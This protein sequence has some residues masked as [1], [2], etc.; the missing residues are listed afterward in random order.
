MGYRLIGMRMGKRGLN[1]LGKNFYDM[2]WKHNGM[3]TG[4]K[5]QN[6]TTRMARMSKVLKSFGTAKASLL[7]H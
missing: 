1:P 7:I 3:K 6:K 4:R 2:V 5:N